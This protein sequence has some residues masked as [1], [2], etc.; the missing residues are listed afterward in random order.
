MMNQRQWLV[1]VS[2]AKEEFRMFT[3]CPELVEQRVVQPEEQK[4]ALSIVGEHTPKN[5]Q[6]VDLQVGKR[7]GERKQPKHN[8]N[9]IYQKPVINNEHERGMKR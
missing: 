6:I 8:V 7:V 9:Q 2:R 4:T 3:D 5:I 1:D